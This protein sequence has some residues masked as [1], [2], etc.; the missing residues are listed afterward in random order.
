MVTYPQNINLRGVSYYNN[1]PTLA[2][3][4]WGPLWILNRLVRVGYMYSFP[5]FYSIWSQYSLLPLI[6]ISFF[7]HST[8]VIFKFSSTFF[9]SFDF[10]LPFRRV[11][12]QSFTVK[13][14][15]SKKKKKNYF[16]FFFILL[17]FFIFTNLRNFVVCGLN[18]IVF[19]V[20]IFF[21]KLL[22][23]LVHMLFF[24][25]LLLVCLAWLG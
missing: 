6:D 2:P 3:K 9:H 23:E 20:C 16:F 25:L 17:F 13:V 14:S 15:L 8:N 5:P 4:F 18:I 10:W 1:N 19:F 12:Y 7:T 11:N 22:V 24:L 21:I